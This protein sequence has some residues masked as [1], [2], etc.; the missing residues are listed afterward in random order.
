MDAE[1]QMIEDLKARV[2][3]LERIVRY[4]VSKLPP[5]VVFNEI[6]GQFQEAEH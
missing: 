2:E 4:G 6:T 5:D 3:V 1:S